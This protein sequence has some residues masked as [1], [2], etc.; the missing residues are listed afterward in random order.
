MPLIRKRPTMLLVVRVVMRTSGGAS[1]GEV[2][3]FVNVDSVF[4][5]GVEAFDG[6]GDLGGGVDGVL[7]ERGESSDVGVVGV[8]DADGMPL[9]VWGC[10]LV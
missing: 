7:A 4:L 10:L 2:S 8:E 1:L 5:V 9:G 6:A 3:E